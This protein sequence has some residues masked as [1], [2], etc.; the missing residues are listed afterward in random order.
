M[1]HLKD[2]TPDPANRRTHNPRNVGMLADALRT[3]GAARS[4]VIDEAGVVLAGN[5][6]VDA[7]AEAG[8]TNVQIVDT[9]GETIVAVRRS[10]LSDEQKRQLALYDNRTAELASWNVAQ[11]AQDKADGLDLQPFWNDGELAILIGAA[12]EP[13]WHGMPGFA[14]QDQLGIRSIVVH[15]KTPED[16]DAFATLVGQSISE[17]TKYLWFPREAPKAVDQTFVGE[18]P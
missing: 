3:V 17:K 10:G 13:D 12:A 9:D 11:L 18:V 8:I 4:I 7:A 5:G 15:F 6:V 1:A 2:L 14:Q 16:V